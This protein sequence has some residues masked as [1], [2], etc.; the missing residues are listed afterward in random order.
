MPHI[1]ELFVNQDLCHNISTRLLYGE[2][3]LNIVLDIHD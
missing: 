2:H 1:L 3:V